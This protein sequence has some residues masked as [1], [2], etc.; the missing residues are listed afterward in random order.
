[1]DGAILK[2]P[3][4]IFTHALAPVIVARLLAPKKDW[5]GRAGLVAIA[6]AGALPDLLSPHITLEQRMTSW[7]HGLPA[8]LGFSALLAAVV[9]FSGKRVSP[10]LA[11]AMSGAYLLH[12]F[13]DAIAGGI[14]WL[15]PF[16]TLTWGEYW[17]GPLWWIPLDATCV[18]TCYYLFRLKPL[19]AHRRKRSEVP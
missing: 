16:G 3:M 1:M 14:D 13:C 8:W 4:N 12:M 17:I 5:A 19:W 9:F 11:T 2:P 7:S 6:F 10:P 18:L 15:H